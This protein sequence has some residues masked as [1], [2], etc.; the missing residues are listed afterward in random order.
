MAAGCIVAPA[1]ACA[2]GSG[3]DMAGMAMGDEMSAASRNAALHMRM[4][5]KRVG[6]AADTARAMTVAAELRAAILKYRDSRVAEADGYRIFLPDAK[7]HVY[8]F[9]NNRAAVR[10]AFRFD[11]ARPTSLL[12]AKGADGAFT[13]E[14]AMYTMPARASEAALNE[15]VPL[16]V[17]QWH[18]HVNWC[19][20]KKGDARRWTETRDGAPL[21]GPQS[22]I[23]TRAA[24]DAAG[25]DFHER[26]FGWMVHANVMADDARA[27]WR[28]E[29]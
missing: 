1:I 16:G 4:T 13:L 7:Q 23:A 12:Y 27:V 10:A 8:H 24:C 17:A 9:T 28:D 19:L 11:P 29:H 15:R 22:A 26:L 3:H 21:F 6:T 25:G 2:Q 20:P 18:Q 14:G 5:A